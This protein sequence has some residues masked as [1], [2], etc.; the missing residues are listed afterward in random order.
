MSQL[1]GSPILQARA[2]TKHFG[3]RAANRSGGGRRVV[4][5][6]VVNAVDGVDV[7]LRPGTTIALVGESGSGKSTVARL[8]AQLYRPSS[9][10]VH[11]RGRQVRVRTGRQRRAYA[12]QVQLLLQDPYASLNPVHTIRYQLARVVRIHGYARGRRQVTEQLHELLCRVS[13]T[14]PEQFLDKYPHELSG[15]QLQR[16][17]IARTLAARPVVLI[18]DE[19]VSMLDVSIR[20]GILNLLRRLTVDQRLALLYITH[21]IASARYFADETQVM[22]LGRIIEGGPSEEL[23]QRPAHPYTRLLISSAP[24]PNR[25]GLIEKPPA[26]A[27]PELKRGLAMLGCRFAARCPNTMDVCVTS[28]PDVTQL[29]QGHWVRCWLHST[30]DVTNGS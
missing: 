8:L 16:V 29:G 7:E 20:L 10:D 1:D 17:A 27:R 2:L 21:D 3:L 22:Y 15:G 18:A 28:T 6:A 14:P 12:R 5:D 24:D 30:K 4:V 19:P 11:L 25:R 13:L 23:T 26:A 9:G